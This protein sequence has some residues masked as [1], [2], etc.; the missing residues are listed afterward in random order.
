M[1][2]TKRVGIWIRVSTDIQEQGDSPEHH[3]QRARYYIQ[4]KET[5]QV[6]EI[7]RLEA[8]SG[9]SVMG[10]P[11]TKRML[12]DIKSGHITGLVF[13]KLARLARNT[14]ELLDFAE[15]FRANN[16]DLISLSESIDTSTPAGRLFYTMIAA[17]AQWER[18][19]IASRVQASVPIRARM[20]KPLGG[21]APFGYKWD[22]ADFVVDK[23]EAPI[24]KLMYELF[25]THQRKHIVAKTLNAKGYVTRNGSQFN[26]TTI[27]R[28]L[29][30]STAMGQRRANYTK[31]TGEKKGWKIKP[32]EEWI[33][34]PCEAIISPDLWHDVNHLLDAQH[35]RR[36]PLRKKAVYLLSGLVQCE[37]GRKMYVYQ[38]SKSYVCRTCKSRITVEDM[39]DIYH[40]HLKEYL[41]SI[42]PDEYLTNAQ[43]RLSESEALFAV[44]Q[45]ERNKLAKRLVELVIL[46]TDGEMTKELFSEHYKPLEQRVL[47]LDSQLLELE[48]EIDVRRVTLYSSDAVMAETKSLHDQWNNMDYPQKRSIVETITTAII[49]GR[50]DIVIKLA[51]T[52]YLPRNAENISHVS[53]LADIIT[54]QRRI[55]C[56]RRVW[57]KNT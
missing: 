22:G 41:Q 37:C 53:A 29:R 40:V 48:A 43:Q 47:L 3:E 50:R 32:Q 46:R 20:G 16:A 31:S 52:P 28:L 57:C 25:I 6:I 15:L 45:K 39:D 19:E 26:A 55:A 17:M 36:D 5:W 14:K 12:S 18:E 42:N 8:F 2:E 10:H 49:I 44:T 34:T 33:I 30:D 7:Y 54:I 35:K 51:Y 38:N 56:A 27:E 21:Q 11:E 23:K 13:S 4:S 24:R 1:N 9:K